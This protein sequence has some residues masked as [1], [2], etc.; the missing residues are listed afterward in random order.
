MPR[1]SK[2]KQHLAKI[3]LLIM[4]NNKYCKDIRQTKKN[5]IF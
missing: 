2:R 1:I 5:R 3:A 4:K